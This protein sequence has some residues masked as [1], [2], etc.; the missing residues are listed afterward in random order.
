[1][2]T[3]DQRIPFED[4]QPGIFS[5]PWYDFFKDM[6]AKFRAA[7]AADGTYDIDGSVAGTVATI[8]ITN[9]IITGVTLR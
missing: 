4:R 1:M 2:N 9:G 3:P 6:A 8:T 5:R 7:P